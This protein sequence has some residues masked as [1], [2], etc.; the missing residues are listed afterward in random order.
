[1]QY[2]IEGQTA[3]RVQETV[4]T[5]PPRWVF[6]C[7]ACGERFRFQTARPRILPR[8]RPSAYVFFDCRGSGRPMPAVGVER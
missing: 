3:T 6:E 5:R 2:A 8:H 1:M 4:R 7:Q